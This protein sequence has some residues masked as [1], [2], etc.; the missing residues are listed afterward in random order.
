[1]QNC[2]LG[3]YFAKKSNNVLPLSV[4]QFSVAT[5]FPAGQ[6]PMKTRLEEIRQ[7]VA[8]GAAEIDVVINRQYALSANWK[9][10]LWIHI[11]KIY[12]TV[13]L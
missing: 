7:A 6:T 10:T 8:D 11:Y 3:F 1:M 2:Q 9:G 13:L 4:I 5:G 12:K